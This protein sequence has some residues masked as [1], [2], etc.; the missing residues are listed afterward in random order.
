MKY[1]FS[2]VEKRYIGNRAGGRDVNTRHRVSGEA[3]IK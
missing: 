2:D 3:V 1:G